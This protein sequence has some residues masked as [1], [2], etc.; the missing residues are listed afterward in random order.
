[1]D[2][3]VNSTNEFTEAGKTLGDL[4]RTVSQGY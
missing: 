2:R 1:M 4:K 3:Y